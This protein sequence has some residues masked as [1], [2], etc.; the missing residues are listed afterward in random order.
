MDWRHRAAC[1][2]EDPELFFPVG[3]SVLLCLRLPRRRLCHRCTVADCLPGSA[4]GQDAGAFWLSEDERRTQAS[5]QIGAA[6]SETNRTAFCLPPHQ[7]AKAEGRHPFRVSALK[8]DI[9][10]LRGTG[11]VAV[12]RSLPFAYSSFP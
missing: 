4:S 8:R 7:K 5:P 10:R 11:S 6:T 3:T 2:D 1:R 12:A 9:C